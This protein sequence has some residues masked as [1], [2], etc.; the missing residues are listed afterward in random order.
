MTDRTST[1]V[2]DDLLM[3]SL[4]HHARLLKADT[5]LSSPSKFDL[6][7]RCVKGLM[8]PVVGGTWTYDEPLTSIE[9]DDFNVDNFTM[10]PK[11]SS[12]ILE[13]MEVDVNRVLPTL[14]E[15]V[16]GFG[17]QVARLAQLAHIRN[18]IDSTKPAPSLSSSR[19]RP[20]NHTARTTAFQSKI[21]ALAMQKLQSFL[22]EYL[23]NQ[24]ADTLLYDA[25]FGGVV[26]RNGL[27]DSE[28]DFG[29]GRYVA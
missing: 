16:Y 14:D 12:A 7:F 24:I 23:N 1:S 8:T 6:L 10:H 17:K 20:K 18:I 4:P 5:L 19:S 2:Q 28:A 13:S 15:N 11:V 27:L 3:L 25:K 29:N 22:E 26:T 9:F 21:S